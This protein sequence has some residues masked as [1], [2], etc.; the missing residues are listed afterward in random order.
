MNIENKS[1]KKSSFY[2]K[3]WNE[4]REYRR[5]IAFFNNRVYLRVCGF[6]HILVKIVVSCRKTKTN[7][8]IKNTCF[9]KNNK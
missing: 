5:R 2:L 9:S 1:G 8:D 4:Y 6:F 3:I 7:L